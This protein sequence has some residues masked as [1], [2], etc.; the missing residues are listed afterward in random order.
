MVNADG[1]NPVRISDPSRRESAPAWS[2]DGTRIAFFSDAAFSFPQVEDPRLMLM[3]PDG[4]GRTT[5]RQ[6]RAIAP[7]WSPDG[8]RLAYATVDADGIIDQ[9]FSIAPDGSGDTQLTTA[10]RNSNPAWR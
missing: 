4:S 7:S 2:P 1:S 3:N 9:I 6:G 5:V 10:G 8:S